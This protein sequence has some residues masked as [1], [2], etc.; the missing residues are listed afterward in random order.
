MGKSV[1]ACPFFN[2]FYLILSNCRLLPLR[3]KY[4][5][6]EIEESDLH[7]KALFCNN[8]FCTL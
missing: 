1:W 6:A 5:F 4:I 7:Q 2:V 3:T 8:F